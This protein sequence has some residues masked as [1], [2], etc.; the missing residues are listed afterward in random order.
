MG[1]R[2]RMRSDP[3]ALRMLA[4]T[5]LAG[6]SLVTAAFLGVL[7]ALMARTVVTP[8]RDYEEDIRVLGVDL[9]TCAVTLNRTPDSVLPGEY[10]LFFSGDTGHA[11]LGPVLANG[12]DWV[13]RR[14][15]RIDF[16]DLAAARNGRLSGWLYLGPWDLRVPF[17]NV[18]VQTPL[19]IAPAWY[20]PPAGPS[21]R[22]AIQVHGRAVRRQ[23]GLRVVP[24]FRDA[25]YHSLLV[26]YRNDGDAP[27]DPT[28]RYGLGDTEW[29]DIDAAIRY[30]MSH[31]AKSI[32]L[33]G[34]SMG[35]AIALQTLMRS[36]H[37]GVVTGL[38][39]ESPVVAWADVLEFQAAARRLPPG[40]A[41]WAMRLMGAP[42]GGRLTGLGAPI[43]FARL[44]F[45]TRAGELAVPI[46]LL[47][48]DDDGYVPAT[49][50]RKLA[51][52]RPDIV[53]FE[54]FDV[55]RHTK[56]W[57]YDPGRYASRVTDWLAGLPGNGSAVPAGEQGLGA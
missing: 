49:G 3:A 33:M 35:G 16:G 40:I 20:V 36:A 42:W 18:V 50:S 44:D 28:G 52:L 43:D 1:E 47:H 37:A 24:V 8:P 25:G 7:T 53:T 9:N 38:V 51:E 30:A 21:D 41:L 10:S 15:L 14:I 12:G 54:R 19:G 48:S 6:S 22:W 29:E 39:L 27:A 57:N 32:V 45:V 23:E 46:L 2:R 13:T 5:V 31:G 17:E 55:A 26:S 11:R 34:W 56:L 4:G